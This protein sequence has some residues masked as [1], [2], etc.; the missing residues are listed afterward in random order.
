MNK[1][2][3]LPENFNFSDLYKNLSNDQIGGIGLLMF[4]QVLIGSA[5]SIV[6]VFFGEY[7]IQRYDLDNK[8]PK[9]AKFIHLRRKFQKYY[10]MLNIFF[11]ISVGIM[12]G[13]FGL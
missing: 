4:S 6:F 9:L 11:I 8:Y 5:I 7:L 12:L 2:K 13:I 3:I 1:S 10:L